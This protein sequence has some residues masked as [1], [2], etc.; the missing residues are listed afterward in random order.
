M[1]FSRQATVSRPPRSDSSGTSFKQLPLSIDTT[2][3]HKLKSHKRLRKVI[4]WR[5]ACRRPDVVQY[6]AQWI[7]RPDNETSWVYEEFF[8]ESAS[9]FDEYRQQNP[10]C[11]P[12]LLGDM[13]RPAVPEKVILPLDTFQPPHDDDPHIDFREYDFVDLEDA[14]SDEGEGVEDVI[15]VSPPGQASTWLYRVRSPTPID[16]NA[17]ALSQTYLKFIQRL[18]KETRTEHT[19]LF[20]QEGL[21][22]AV[23]ALRNQQLLD[24]TK[25]ETLKPDAL[26]LIV[27]VWLTVCL[28][29]LTIVRSM[30]QSPSFLCSSLLQASIDIME[31]QMPSVSSSQSSTSSSRPSNT[32]RQNVLQWETCLY[33]IKTNWFA[34]D[35]LEQIPAALHQPESLDDISKAY[36]DALS[37]EG[38]PGLVRLVLNRE[39]NFRETEK[40]SPLQEVLSR[41]ALRDWAT[42]ELIKIFASMDQDLLR[43]CLSRRV[44]QDSKSSYSSVS[45][46]L[47]RNR[48]PAETKRP[49]IYANMICDRAGMSPTPAQW[50]LVCDHLAAYIVDDVD[51]NKL[52]AKID[53]AIHPT[54]IWPKKLAQEGL[55]RYLDPRRYL[56]NRGR[57][58]HTKDPNRRAILAVFLAEMNERIS[59][60]ILLG[61]CNAPLEASVIEIGY[62]I[63]PRSRLLEHANHVNSNYLMNLS[64]SAFQI[65][66]P[67]RFTLQQQII[68]HCWR[69]SQPWLAEIAFTQICQ[70]YTQRAGGFSHYPAGYSNDSAFKQL[71]MAEWTILE[72][73]VSR[74]GVLERNFEDSR[75]LLA[76]QQTLLDDDLKSEARA[77]QEDAETLILLDQSLQLRTSILELATLEL[78]DADE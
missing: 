24:D 13:P 41:R 29:T 73:E 49:V 12:D 44:S 56:K 1:S 23:E 63:N 61:R 72:S 14:I 50:K 4:G 7:G 68:Y 69:S 3:D 8:T 78:V 10:D 27:A 77:A 25:G 59:N 55:R 26:A 6:L 70:G 31:R 20:T 43:S 76:Q 46:T 21:I 16:K 64:Q 5:W 33:N 66:F 36:L 65:L 62:T 47:A 28:R 11:P 53:Q 54:K 40:V 9:L 37:T 42:A 75:K 30:M 74:L 2:Q 38:I 58:D 19:F 57:P 39:E 51:G 34:G 15:V 22:H 60:E 48:L 18:C 52:A 32:F 17:I 71:A 67:G 35:W 45:A